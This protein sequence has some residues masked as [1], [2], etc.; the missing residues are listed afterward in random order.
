MSGLRLRRALLS[1][2]LLLPIAFALIGRRAARSADADPSPF[3]GTWACAPDARV[4][5]SCE[6]GQPLEQPL[7]GTTVAVRAG[8]AAAGETA[9]LMFELGC[10]CHVPLS[11]SPSDPTLATLVAPT[12]CEV[13]LGQLSTVLDIQKLTLRL[14]SAVMRTLDIDL[15]SGPSA[16]PPACEST[17]VVTKLLPFSSVPADCGPDATA[18]G[19]LSYGPDGF[20]DCPLGAG[21]DSVQIR[22]YLESDT[23]CERGTG[24]RGEGAWVLPQ[25]EKRKPSCEPRTPGPAAM[26]IPFCRVDG[27]SF[28]PLT[29]DP[30]ATEQFYALLK[31]GDAA[32]PPAALEMVR[33]IDN[34]DDVADQMMSTAIGQAGPN[35]VA[36]PTD[37]STALHFCF[38]RAAATPEETMPSF[39]ELGFPYAVFHD[40]DG[41]QPA[42]A[43]LKRWVYSS[44]E[45]ATNGNLLTSPSGDATAMNQ[46]QSII[47]M[48][49]HAT[50][51]DLAW[52]R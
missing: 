18:L 35:K 26:T 6:G 29:A 47:E 39:P 30:T 51:F 19:V 33:W 42:W 40:F 17:S 16:G 2:S 36:T 7:A 22:L 5:A 8:N 15:Q 37:T 46:F 20:R 24:T 34:E 50:T 21:W 48:P 31:L 52:V 45:V 3:V 23:V 12:P 11:V 28:K 49:N 32:C 10:H 41:P 44:D 14:G 9:D 1:A 38:F 4:I 13:I 43:T 27:R 25:T